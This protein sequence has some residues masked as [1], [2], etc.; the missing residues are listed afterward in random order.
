MS[1]PEPGMPV[2]RK[3]P[4]GGVDLRSFHTP[5]QITV[6]SVVDRWTRHEQQLTLVQ[7]SD[8]GYE[9]AH[10]LVEER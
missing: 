5:D 2:K 1:N 10:N 4:M 9:F 8:G 6:V 7:L 3:H